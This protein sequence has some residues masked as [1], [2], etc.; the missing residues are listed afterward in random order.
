M[1]VVTSILLIGTS[2]LML[3]VTLALIVFVVGY[4]IFFDPKATTAGRM[5]FRFMVSLTGVFVLTIV[6]SFVF[7][8]V[9]NE[10]RGPTIWSTLW[11]LL[12]FAIIAYVAFTITTLFVSLVLRKWFPQRVKKRSDLNLLQ[13]RHDTTDIPIIKQ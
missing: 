13:P 7:P 8:L 12:S 5:L 4:Y 10:A 3:Y 11:F 6:N 2:L 1:D 9:Y